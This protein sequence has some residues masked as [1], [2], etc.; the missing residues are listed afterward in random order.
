MLTLLGQNM[1]TDDQAK[2]STKF[3]IADLIYY[4]AVTPQSNTKEDSLLLRE[5]FLQ[6][7]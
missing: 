3:E 2:A 1:K 5:I 6:I 7:E 4:I